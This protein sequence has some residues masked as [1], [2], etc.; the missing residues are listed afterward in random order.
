MEIKANF[1]LIGI[2]TLA[3]FG[4]V[5]AA[6]LWLGA[7]RIDRDVAR[8][9][10]LFPDVSGLALSGDVVFNGLSVG[11]VTTLRLHEE[12]PAL[13]YA[14]IE[15]DPAT[16]V[17]ADTVAQL[18]SQGV[19]GVAHIALIGGTAEA[20][21]LVSDPE[22]PA[23]IPA[24]RAALQTLITDVPDLLEEATGLLADLRALSGPDT[25]QS[26]A[27]IVGN[28]ESA[29]AKLD[30]TLDGLAALTEGLSAAAVQIGGV[31]DT[32]GSLEGDLRNTLAHA[33]AALGSATAS[34]DAATPTL[35]DASEVLAATR[36][37]VAE[38][39]PA[40][41]A[42]WR[43]TAGRL[44]R[45]LANADSAVEA[46]GTA[47][48]MVG[49]LASGDAT[50]VLANARQAMETAG[51]AIANDVPA[52]LA[53]LRVAASDTRRALAEITEDLARATDQLDPLA[54]DARD[55]LRN[56]SG[57]LERAQPSLDRLDTALES[58]DHA[59]EAAAGLLETDIGPAIGDL[60]EAA[61]AVAR[62]LPTI[63]SQA[64]AVLRDI[65]S[66][67]DAVAPGLRA[68]GASTLPEFGSLADEARG[69]VQAISDLVRR[70]ERDPA[71][72]LQRGQVPEFRR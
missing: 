36:I 2:F 12:D 60:R 10:I 34:F 19:T 24:R 6:F 58:A 49:N 63:T 1:L 61:A 53:D 44:D 47:S 72:F 71:R 45:S 17:R 51:P 14:G 7:V 69:L 54:T 20:P 9:G 64:D 35:E 28:V 32:L 46:F 30:S 23:L 25:R 50:A 8:Y 66:V 31:G 26:V 37:L 70:I 15:I 59:F 4:A 13:I 5:L 22:A 68:F 57:V 21:P 27:N 40:T 38:D 29:S 41:L 11:R 56:A 16:P 65:S 42:D 39:A 33:N 43:T 3:G 48:E 62:D 18:T 67:V 52:A 55:A